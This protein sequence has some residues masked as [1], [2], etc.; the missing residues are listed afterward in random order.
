MEITLTWGKVGSMREYNTSVLIY[1]LRYA[2]YDLLTSDTMSS[3]SPRKQFKSPRGEKNEII[4][5]YA[6]F[7]HIV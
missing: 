3:S 4:L 2:R 6:S 1:N 7:V 5:F